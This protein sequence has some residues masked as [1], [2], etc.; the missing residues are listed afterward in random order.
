[1][2][3]SDK[4]IKE[5]AVLKYEPDE[6]RAPKIIALGK[7]EIAQKIIDKA[8]ELDIPIYKDENIAHTLN[9]LNLGDQIPPELYEMVA[10]ILVFV[11]S[12]DKKYRR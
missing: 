10:Q 3:E 7:G 2:S 5:V 9:M 6:D 1:M 11:S 12:I 8:E 4:E